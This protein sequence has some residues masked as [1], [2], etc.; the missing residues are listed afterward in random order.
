MNESNPDETSSHG[1]P[2]SDHQHVDDEERPI[3]YEFAIPAEEVALAE[4]LSE[5]PDV[6][7]EFEQLIPTNH[8][9]L[10]YFWATDGKAPAFQKA[11]ADDPH[12]AHVQK[13]ST[14]EGGA[15]YGVVWT[16]DTDGLLNWGANNHEKIAVLEAY[17][18][19][20]EWVL[21]LRFPTRAHLSDFQAFCDERSIE[22]RVIRLY[23]L[24]APK[25][26]EY[27]I[28]EKQREALLQALEMGHFEIP[29]EAILKDIGESLDI[30]PRAVSERLRRGQ[31]N[32]IS[33]SLTIRR[34]VGIGVGDQE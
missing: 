13:T 4:A 32:L 29:R 11:V 26:G 18:R 34:P 24:T 2:P 9:P 33:N 21:K 16:T 7:I 27:N 28:S 15:L 30:S 3:V 10:P 6:A 19:T 5:F 8:S 22:P 25:M 23:D 17:G 1:T 31:T 12:V 14:F 20:D